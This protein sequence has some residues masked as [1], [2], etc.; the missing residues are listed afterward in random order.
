[1]ATRADSDTVA[2]GV[3]SLDAWMEEQ[4]VPPEDIRFIKVDGIGL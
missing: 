4:G 1:M 2:C 3:T